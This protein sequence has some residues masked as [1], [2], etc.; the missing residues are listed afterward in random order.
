MK[1]TIFHVQILGHHRQSY[2]AENAMDAILYACSE[3]AEFAPDERVY[4][5]AVSTEGSREILVGGESYTV[6]I[7]PMRETEGG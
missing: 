7:A 2:E 6:T 3:A 5:V 4:H 1:P